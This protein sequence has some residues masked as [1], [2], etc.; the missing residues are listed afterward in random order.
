MCSFTAPRLSIGP[1]GVIRNDTGDAM[2]AQQRMEWEQELFATRQQ[3]EL[4]RQFKP[5]QE[6]RV[7]AAIGV[8][9]VLLAAC[10]AFA[11]VFQA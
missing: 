10:T 3:L 2:T 9:A 11:M 1:E 7:V 5:M 4:L 8:G 6:R